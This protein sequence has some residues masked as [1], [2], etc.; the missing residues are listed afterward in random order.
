MEIT[1]SNY[2]TPEIRSRYMTAST[3]KSILGTIGFEGCEAKT[4]A[5]I[6]GWKPEFEKDSTAL[7]VGSYVDSYFEGTLDEFILKNPEVFTE[8]Y[9]LNDISKIGDSHKTKT[10]KIKGSMGDA[11]QLFP[12]AFTKE[13]NLKA[14]YKHALK[15]IEYI[16]RDNIFMNSLNGDK[17]KILTG[18]IEGV[19]FMGKTDFIHNASIVDLKV[20]KDMKPQYVKGV[21][22]VTFIEYWGIDTQLAIYQELDYQMTG[23]LKDCIVS[24]ATKQKPPEKAVISIPQEVLDEAMN[25]LKFNIN[26]IKDFFTSSSHSRCE[27]CDFCLETKNVERVISMY[28]L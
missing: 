6:N 7:L 25:R 3:V 18:E 4:Y 16:E 17:Q 23:V 14:P 20:M 2:Y 24:C 26:I 9:T 8:K 27:K 21:G 19:K 1:Q 11:K 22:Y 5:R 13:V 12:D 15:I 28:E 10:G